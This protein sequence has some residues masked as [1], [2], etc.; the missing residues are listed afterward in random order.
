MNDEKSINLPKLYPRLENPLDY[1]VGDGINQPQRNMICVT[2]LN[3]YDKDS[4]E[5]IVENKDNSVLN[6]SPH[7]E[8]VLESCQICNPNLSWFR[9]GVPLP[10]RRVKGGL[11]PNH[12]ITTSRYRDL[13][14]KLIQREENTEVINAVAEC[15]TAF[16]KSPLDREQTVS[17]T[18]SKAVSTT[19]KK[20]KNSNKSRKS[21]KKKKSRR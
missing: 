2:C 6:R 7:P 1:V 13:I 11:G 17:P 3:A 8:P 5:K 10:G 12:T 14:P 15:G 9:P 18:D 16:S 21:R 19:A 20:A 4:T